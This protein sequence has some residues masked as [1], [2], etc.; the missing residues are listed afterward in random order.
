LYEG[1]GPVG[2]VWGSDVPGQTAANLGDVFQ[3]AFLSQPGTVPRMG[4]LGIPALVLFGIGV[5]H[6]K[7]RR[8]ALFFIFCGAGLLVGAVRAGDLLP[9]AFPP[10][11]LYFPMTF[12][13]AMSAGLGCDRLLTPKRDHRSP[14]IWLPA[15]VT[16]GLAGLIF[17]FAW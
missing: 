2:L 12:C 11:V 14:S 15:S 5:F 17:R 13:I 6:R 3:Q 10:E 16:V 4:Y 8:E 7:A 9:G 1:A